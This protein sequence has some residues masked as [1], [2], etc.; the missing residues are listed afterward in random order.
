MLERGLSWRSIA[1]CSGVVA[2]LA[3]KASEISRRSPDSPVCMAV[4]SKDGASDCDHASPI[5]RTS[6]TF[7]GS[8]CASATCRSDPSFWRST[9]AH[10]SARKGTAR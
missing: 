8:T 4:R 2:T 7:A 10:Q 6:P 3:R 5:S 9:A 1:R